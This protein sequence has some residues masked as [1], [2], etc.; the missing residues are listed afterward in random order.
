MSLF[1]SYYIEQT[2]G[3][4][5]GGGGPPDTPFFI[6]EKVQ[7]E[8][9]LGAAKVTWIPNLAG[10]PG[11]HFI[12]EYRKQGEPSYLRTNPQINEDNV[13]ISGLETANYEFRVISVDGENETPS[14]S[15]LFETK[16]ND[17]NLL[18]S[19]S[20]VRCIQLKLYKF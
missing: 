18:L 10:T 14:V 6:I 13:E 20:N 17:G 3:L 12:V 5:V 9:Q 16:E 8:S 4:G 11:S 2:T 19:F 7:S 15:Q 1:L